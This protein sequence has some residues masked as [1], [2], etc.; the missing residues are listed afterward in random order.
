VFRDTRV[1]PGPSAPR[2]DR[3]P[4]VECRS[5]DPLAEILDRSQVPNTLG[6]CSNRAATRVNILKC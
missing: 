5:N 4:T 3:I 6:R 1:D 2:R